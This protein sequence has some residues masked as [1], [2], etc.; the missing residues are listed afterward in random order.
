MRLKKKITTLQPGQTPKCKN[1]VPNGISV[2]H[3]GIGSPL[4]TP[5]PS[6]I[7]WLGVVANCNSAVRGGDRQGGHPGAL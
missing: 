2:Y 1:S 5:I 3:L 6:P 7:F 4:H